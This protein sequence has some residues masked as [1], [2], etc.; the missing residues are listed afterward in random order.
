MDTRGAQAEAAL[1]AA[2]CG[3]RG[4]MWLGERRSRGARQRMSSMKIYMIS[5]KD[6]RIGPMC[7]PNLRYGIELCTTMNAFMPTNNED[8]D[9]MATRIKALD[10]HEFEA[11]LT[12][13][14]TWQGSF[15]R[16]ESE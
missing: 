14:K 12:A 2:G 5:L 7:D 9:D 11:L 4:G 8:W 15:K 10:D 3:H 6:M 1:N 13:R 16:E